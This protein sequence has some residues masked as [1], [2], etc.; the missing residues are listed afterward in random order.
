MK[1]KLLFI[2][3]AVTLVLA[4]LC[5]CGGNGDDTET[6][7]CTHEWALK[8]G[9]E[10]SATCDVG[11]TDTF[12][13]TLCGEEKE[14]A[15]EALGHDFQRESTV[16]A[17]CIAGG[18]DVFKC[19]R[20]EATENRN[21]TS[22]S[23]K[24]EAHNF[25]EIRVEPTCTTR[26]SSETKCTLCNAN[27]GDKQTLQALKHTY[28][29]TYADG[30]VDK[31]V[32]STVKPTCEKDGSITYSC[33]DC[34]KASIT[35]TYEDLSAETASDADKKL[36]AT[37]KALGHD[38]S[39][40]KEDKP[41]ECLKPGYKIMSCKNGCGETENAATY[42]PLGHSYEREGAEIVFGK[43]T[44]A[45]TCVAEGLQWAVCAD[46]SYSADQD[47]IPTEAY[48]Q[49]IPATGVHDFVVYVKTTNPTCTTS[50]YDTYRCANCSNTDQTQNMVDPQPHTWVLDEDMLIDG[51]PYCLTNGKYPYY[52]SAMWG[53]NGNVPCAEFAKDGG[54]RE[55]N[56]NG[57]EVVPIKHA[58]VSG[59]WTIAPTCITPATYTCT[60]C[61]DDFVAYEEDT[62]AQATGTHVYTITN[63]ETDTVLPT[64]TTYGYTT[65]YCSSDTGCTESENRDF[66]ARVPHALGEVTSDG[67]V[68]CTVAGCGATFINTTTVIET[69]FDGISSEGTS[70]CTDPFCGGC[71]YD[72][73]LVFVTASTAPKAAEALKLPE[74]ATEG[75]YS[76]TK[77]VDSENPITLFEILGVP[78]AEY[79]IKLFNGEDEVTSFKADIAGEK[80]DVNIT[81]NTMYTDEG[82]LYI[83]IAE[84][85]KSV[86]SI[87]I[88]C[89]TEAS[90]N[91]YK[92]Q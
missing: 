33:P 53:K 52:C 42:E 48:S 7:E 56:V 14:E 23:T 27:Q 69:E 75:T 71:D 84:V 41:A 6:A 44:L 16:E 76:L 36:A 85:A 5:A 81:Y 11:G 86:T 92:F 78:N 9:T 39:V 34:N 90:V 1:K 30:E 13:C 88:E 87:V 51:N 24:P 89:E 20:C 67:I 10:T 54:K 19:S 64:C 55:Y 77:T 82:Y 17:T 47:E 63:P 4:T 61:T 3:L 74:G 66:T 83:D 50:G 43:V 29:R 21:E 91:F 80:V 58:Y 22:I 68:A 15:V 57:E 79:T 62:A 70:L 38:F 45:P 73:I 72:N 32:V 65:Y 59:E 2:L 35:K 26:G 40:V 25:E 60:Q 49:K 37:I 18:Y 8:E 31:T 46:C 12:T 28:E